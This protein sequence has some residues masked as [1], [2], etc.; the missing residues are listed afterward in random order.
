MKTIK[1]NPIRFIR[2][3]PKIDIPVFIC[4]GRRDYTTPFELSAEYLNKLNAPQKELVWFENSAHAPNFEEPDAFQ[5]FC[6][7][8]L[9]PCIV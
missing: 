1:Q 8:K 2:D 9:K 4:C 6:I 7:T 3:V 5:S